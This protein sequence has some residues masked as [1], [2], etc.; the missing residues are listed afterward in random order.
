MYPTQLELPFD[1]LSHFEARIPYNTMCNKNKRWD[2][3]ITPKSMA[4]AFPYIQMNYPYINYICLDLDYREAPIAAQE[5]GLPAP[6]LTVITPDSNHAHLLYELLYPIPRKH[7]KATKMLLKDVLYVYKE[8]LCADK[9]ITTQRQLIKNPLC[10]KWDV[11]QGNAPYTLTELAESKPPGFVM[12]RTYEP[13]KNVVLG[14]L[15]FKDTLDLHSRNESLFHN[16]RYYA[17]VI[18]R[19]HSI[20]KSLYE[21]MLS[22]VIHLNDT[23]ITKYFPT[24]IK[25]KSELRSIAGSI[26]RWTF[27]RRHNFKVVDRGA[28]EFGEMPGVCWDPVLKKPDKVYQEELARRQWLSAERTAK[29]KR[30]S[31]EDKIRL[32]VE[33]CFKR[34]I[35]P[36]ATN[37]A[38]FAQVNRTTVWRHSDVL[39][40]CV[41]LGVSGKVC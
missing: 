39:N 30:E 15:P 10:S 17:Y 38:E 37:V 8:I 6:T 21:A 35:D 12:K 41:A 20:Y 23:E 31:T 2:G 28:M 33:T 1:A 36:T 19:E 3:Y 18:A 25:C 27:K 9:V 26:S 34:G 32:A 7:S 22:R 16:A 24:K 14:E 11:I 29:I 13:R 40:E 5:H 4:H